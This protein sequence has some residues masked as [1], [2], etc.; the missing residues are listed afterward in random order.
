MDKQKILDEIKRTTKENGGVP[1]GMER[2]ARDL[3]VKVHEWHGKYW[4]RWSDALA[5]AGFEP[6]KYNIAYSDDFVLAKLAIFV[7]EL[8]HYPINAE[9]KMKARADRN[10]PSNNVFGRLG[11]KNE[12]NLK[13]QK[14]CSQHNEYSDVIPLLPLPQSTNDN[15]NITVVSKGYVYLMKHGSRSE[16]KIGRTNNVIR[17]EGELSIELPEKLSPIHTIETDDPA[18]IEKYWH[19]RFSQKR[20][21]GEWFSLSAE[22]VKA[23]KRWKRIC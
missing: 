11:N 4:L 17:R 1:L 5:E 2:F 22:D 18:G 20:K 19:S 16:Y 21:N 13:L 7:I 14:F 10:F 23:F 3:G 12:L 15:E 9:L 6:N 8:G